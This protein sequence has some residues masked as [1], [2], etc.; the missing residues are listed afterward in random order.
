MEWQTE[1]LAGHLIITKDD[2]P[3]TVHRQHFYIP[4][5]EAAGP[6]ARRNILRCAECDY[7]DIRCVK[8]WITW[9]VFSRL[10]PVEHFCFCRNNLPDIR[11]VIELEDDF[12]TGITFNGTEDINEEFADC[13][14]E[15]KEKQYDDVG[16]WFC[17]TPG[18]IIRKIRKMTDLHYLTFFNCNSYDFPIFQEIGRLKNL[19]GLWLNGWQTLFDLDRA[20]VGELRK[21]KK[22]ETLSIHFGTRIAAEALPELGSL[23]SLKGLNLQLGKD[24]I[25]GNSHKTTAEALSFLPELENLEVLSLHVTPRLSPRDLALPPNLKYLSINGNVCRLPVPPAKSPRKTTSK[26]ASEETKHDDGE[27]SL[28]DK[29]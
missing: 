1:K 23:K 14:K 2:A 22:L 15:I 18:S 25:T 7:P 13:L 5:S 10:F 4:A 24:C 6:D 19:R 20:A 12:S 29:E 9:R 11:Y 17:S 26:P 28:F 21:L 3:V 27:Q 16:F 8:H